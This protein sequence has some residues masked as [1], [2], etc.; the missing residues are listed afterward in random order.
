MDLTSQRQPCSPDLTPSDFYFLPK[1]KEE[2]SGQHCDNDNDVM[3]AVDRFTEVQDTH[4]VR[5][6]T[7]DLSL[8]VS[9]ENK[10]VFS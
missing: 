2:L 5:G 3:A 8:S 1:M 6:R 4:F 9:E 10:C 7:A